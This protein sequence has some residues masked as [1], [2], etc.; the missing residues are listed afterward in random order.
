MKVHNMGVISGN[1]ASHIFLI[2]ANAAGRRGLAVAQL[3]LVVLNLL[4]SG[5]KKAADRSAAFLF[6]LALARVTSSSARVSCPSRQ[7]I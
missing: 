5:T 6:D 3:L 2:D 7:V 4:R 1:V